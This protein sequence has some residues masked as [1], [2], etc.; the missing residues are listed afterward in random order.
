MS[1]HKNTHS[2][3]ARPWMLSAVLAIGCLL[4]AGSALAQFTTNPNNPNAPVTAPRGGKDATEPVVN[5]PSVAPL[6]MPVVAAIQAATTLAREPLNLATERA[7]PAGVVTSS[8]LML[9]AAT[10][11]A[12]SAVP[13]ASSMVPAPIRSLPPMQPAQP[14]FAPA[15][16]PVGKPVPA[17]LSPAVPLPVG[18]VRPSVAVEPAGPAVPAAPAVTTPAVQP[19]TVGAPVGE[20][21]RVMRAP[22]ACTPKTNS[23]DCVQDSSE[24]GQG[25][26]VSGRVRN[27][28]IG[29]VGA[30][31]ATTEGAGGAQRQAT[32]TPKPGELSCSN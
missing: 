24:A 27:S 5:A 4:A 23:L 19:V 1:T 14:V 21:V 17:V 25:A 11:P 31:K 2:G 32:C 10:L 29:E 3:Q 30:G 28:V 15:L 22:A 8:Q 9:A 20:G 26:N 16:P 6:P 12:L 13:V 18:G 7:L